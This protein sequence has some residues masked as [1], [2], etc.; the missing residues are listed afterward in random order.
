MAKQRQLGWCLVLGLSVA[1]VI[2]VAVATADGPPVRSNKTKSVPAALVKSTAPNPAT[3]KDVDLL[4]QERLLR[5]VRAE[6]LTREVS[7]TLDAAR[8]EGQRDPD[9]AL[10]AL[11]RIL[12]TVLSSG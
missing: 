5:E 9:A 2:T 11:K 8:R 4:E 6:R 12:V 10:G 3:V 1:L 7:Q